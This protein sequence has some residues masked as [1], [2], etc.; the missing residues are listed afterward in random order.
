MKLG[1]G[2]ASPNSNHEQYD[3]G[4]KIYKQNGHVIK[5]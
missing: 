4:N 1:S 2:E 3:F 5:A